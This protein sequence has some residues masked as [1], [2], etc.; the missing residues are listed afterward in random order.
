[1]DLNPITD[2]LLSI[3]S[4]IQGK[5][6]NMAFI[7]ITPEQIIGNTCP[8]CACESIKSWINESGIEHGHQFPSEVRH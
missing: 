5:Y 2:E 6:P 3:V 4:Y 8:L 7:I 1:M